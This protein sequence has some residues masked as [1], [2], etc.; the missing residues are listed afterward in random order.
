MHKMCKPKAAEAAAG[1]QAAVDT[2]PLQAWEQ[3]MTTELKEAMQSV[4]CTSILSLLFKHTVAC[5]VC[6]VAVA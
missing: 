5:V 1:A 3:D 6:S 4:V 2:F